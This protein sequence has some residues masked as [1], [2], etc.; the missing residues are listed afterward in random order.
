MRDNEVIVDGYT[1]KDAPVHRTHR[2]GTI[3]IGLCFIGFGV[4]FLLHTLFGLFTYE[5]ITALWPIILIALGVEVLLANVIGEN[6]VYDKA[7]AVMMV[8]MG[9]FAMS[10]AFVDICFKHAEFFYM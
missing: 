8:I 10:M 9:L 1:I 6:F 5:M 2:V 4:L 7:G 3:T